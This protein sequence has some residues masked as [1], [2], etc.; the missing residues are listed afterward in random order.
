MLKQQ[1][2][3]NFI[4]KNTHLRQ[5]NS[6][7][8]ALGTN[9]G[10]L[11][12]LFN[13]DQHVAS[14]VFTDHLYVDG[15]EIYIPAFDKNISSS[16]S[17]Q[18]RMEAHSFLEKEVAKKLGFESLTSGYTD[19]YPQCHMYW[20]VNINPPFAEHTVAEFPTPPIGKPLHAD[21]EVQLSFF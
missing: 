19:V 5:Y 8:S 20:D 16:D 11:A 15:R 13:G 1:S 12:M 17:L 3:Q 9:P 21:T 18:A 6:S 4:L 2:Y 7:R 10:K 14:V